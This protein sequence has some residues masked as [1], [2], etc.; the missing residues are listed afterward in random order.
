MFYTHALIE[1]ELIIS[2][3]K[4]RQAKFVNQTNSLGIETIRFVNELLVCLINNLI[5]TIDHLTGDIA[6]WPQ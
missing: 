2:S 5:M 6:V 1:K 4:G 3:K